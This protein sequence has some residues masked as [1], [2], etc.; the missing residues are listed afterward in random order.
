MKKVVNLALLGSILSPF[1]HANGVDDANDLRSAVAPSMLS[2]LHQKQE[3]EKPLTFLDQ[4]VQQKDKLKPVA[5]AEKNTYAKQL[6]AQ[7]DYYNVN[8]DLQSFIKKLRIDDGSI[9]HNTTDKAIEIAIKNE[10][11][12]SPNFFEKKKVTLKPGEFYILDKKEDVQLSSIKLLKNYQNF[13]LNPKFTFDGILQMNIEATQDRHFFHQKHDFNFLTQKFADD[14]DPK[15]TPEQQQFHRDFNGSYDYMSFVADQEGTSFEQ[16]LNQRQELYEKN[17]IATL[18]AKDPL[19]MDRAETKIPLITHKIWVTSDDA[20]KDPS[21][22]YIKWLENSIEH[23]QREDG[24]RHI[25]WVENKEKLPNLAKLLEN[26]PNIELK[27]LDALDTNEFVTK[28]LYKQAIKDK[29]FARLLT[30]SA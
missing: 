2:P 9:F 14:Q 12:I 5:A 3:I 6:A 30:L 4:L 13:Y 7:R 21:P 24:W 16:I 1:S 28:N 22:Q 23:N 8:A 25:F 26:H 15:L 10:S 17:N 29:K 20:P 11:K 18:M 19:L 27:E